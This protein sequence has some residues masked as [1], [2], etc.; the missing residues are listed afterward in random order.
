MGEVIKKIGYL[1]VTFGLIFGWVACAGTKTVNA[2]TFEVNL[3]VDGTWSKEAV[4][5]DDNNASEVTYK[6]YY[7]LEVPSEGMLTTTIESNG[8]GIGFQV[9]LEDKDTR[10]KDKRIEDGTV[11]KSFSFNFSAGT[12]Y[13]MVCDFYGNGG[14]GGTYKVKAEYVSFGTKETKDESQFNPTSLSV[15]KKLAGALTYNDKEDWYKINIAAKG[16]YTF[17]LQ[18]LAG[19]DSGYRVQVIIYNKDASE[20]VAQYTYLSGIYNNNYN[21]EINLNKGT[22][23]IWVYQNY[24]N[25]GKYGIKITPNIDKGIVKSFKKQSTTSAKVKLKKLNGVT[26]YQ[27]VLSTSKNMKKN[28]KVVTLKS[29]TYKFKKLKKGKTYYI[30]CRGIYNNGNKNITGKWSAKKKLVM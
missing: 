28:R 2:D 23:L 7:K 5:G 10:V 18:Q 6:H 12:Y 16:Q 13:I 19:V 11:T 17:N 26:G 3:S 24:Q 21:E 8:Y 20:K 15:G 22:Y 4:I 1:I 27:V 9:L 14:D 25:F 29:K 30:R